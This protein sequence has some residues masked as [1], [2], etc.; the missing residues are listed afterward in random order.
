MSVELP[1]GGS[2]LFGQFLR[3][4]ASSWRGTP[5]S[6]WCHPHWDPTPWWGPGS[7]PRSGS[8]R[9]TAWQITTPWWRWIHSYPGMENDKQGT[10]SKGIPFIHILVKSS[11]PRGS[12]SAPGTTENTIDRSTVSKVH[13][14]VFCFVF[15]LIL[16]GPSADRHTEKN[17]C[18]WQMSQFSSE[19]WETD[20]HTVDGWTGRYF[21]VKRA[22][23][24]HLENRGEK[25]VIHPGKLKNIIL[26][27]VLFL[28]ISG[29]TEIRK[30]EK[31]HTSEMCATRMFSPSLLL[32]LISPTAKSSWLT[33]FD[34]GPD[35]L[36]TKG[37]LRVCHG[38]NGRLV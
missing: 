32:P 6:R 8:G 23:L 25:H 9:W 19:E 35:E 29:K 15:W 33:R 17:K 18:L 11:S 26:F 21:G 38:E 2:P 36:D 37:S 7:R 16:L 31:T 30:R 28:S 20:P 4:Y 27:V 5:W 14:L 22:S 3:S 24:A 1:W 34:L 12:R 13:E 10:S